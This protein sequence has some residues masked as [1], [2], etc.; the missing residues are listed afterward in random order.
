MAFLTELSGKEITVGEVTVPEV[1]PFPDVAT[2]TQKQAK[3][4][5]LEDFLAIR[6]SR[7]SMKIMKGERAQ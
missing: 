5:G 3:T 2:L 7:T 6:A 1:A 4:A